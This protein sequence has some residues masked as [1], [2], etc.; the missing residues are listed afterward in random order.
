MMPH[1]IM[2]F[3]VMAHKISKTAVSSSDYHFHD[4]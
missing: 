2:T 3:T 1:L 4:T